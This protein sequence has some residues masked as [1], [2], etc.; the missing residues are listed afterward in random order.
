MAIHASFAFRT[1]MMMQMRLNNK[2]KKN[3]LTFY[4]SK[5]KQNYKKIKKKIL[6]LYIHYTH[7]TQGTNTHIHTRFLGI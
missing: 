3:D 7:D 1:R 4:K 6:I 2:I 5:E